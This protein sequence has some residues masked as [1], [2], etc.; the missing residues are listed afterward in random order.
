MA[1][2][3]HETPML[4]ELETG[5]WPSFVTG[6]KRLA[7]LG[8]WGHPVA[9]GLM[10]T[11]RM[12]A[13]RRDEVVRFV[14]ALIASVRAIKADRELALSLVRAQGVPEEFVAGTV[15]ITLPQLD[16]DGYLPATTQQR[17]I[18]TSARFLGLD[19]PIPTS[20]VFDSSVLDDAHRG[21]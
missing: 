5:P 12:L 3:P 8:Q 19:G 4:D 15:D 11:D 14:R 10:T 7:H 18:D 6:L 16:T 17:W 21:A 1:K 13:E 20:R 2:K 9:Y